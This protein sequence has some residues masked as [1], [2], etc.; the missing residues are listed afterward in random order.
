MKM[1]VYEIYHK[2]AVIRM[3]TSL[4]NQFFIFLDETL[5]STESSMHFPFLFISRL[6]IN[7]YLRNVFSFLLI[8][9][10]RIIRKYKLN[11]SS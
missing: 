7:S 6:V 11:K 8:E 3:N 5:G 1:N 10:V 2:I 4:E 9:I